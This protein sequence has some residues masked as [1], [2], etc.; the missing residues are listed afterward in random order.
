MLYE[1]ITFRPCDNAGQVESRVL[2][3][4]A[5]DLDDLAVEKDNLGPQ[6]V[7][8]RDPVFQAA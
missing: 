1:V 4:L 5:A 7:V 3:G 6:D 8:T 2:Q